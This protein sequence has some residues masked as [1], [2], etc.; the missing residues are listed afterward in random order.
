MFVPSYELLGLIARA[1]F[2]IMLYIQLIINT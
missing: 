2:V 1:S